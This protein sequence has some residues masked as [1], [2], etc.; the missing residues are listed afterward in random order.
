MAQK[1]VQTLEKRTGEERN[2]GERIHPVSKKE[3]LVIRVCFMV[4]CFINDFL[5]AVWAC[6]NT[7][8]I[9]I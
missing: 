7:S 8:F 3:A 6:L 5:N 9:Q 4:I 1:N 2:M